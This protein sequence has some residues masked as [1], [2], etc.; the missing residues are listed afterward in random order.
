VGP[1]KKSGIHGA[2]STK[3]LSVI[4]ALIFPGR[5]FGGPRFL[6]VAFFAWSVAL[7]KILT[8]DNFRKRHVIVVNRCYLCKRN[9]ESLNHLLLHCEVA[10]ALWNAFL[11]HFG[12]SWVMPSRVV[13][14][15]TW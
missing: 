9:W 3:S 1:F 2:P 11:C 8:M 7:Q 4:M 6:R 13:D 5:V 14:L 12:L 15:F 10:C